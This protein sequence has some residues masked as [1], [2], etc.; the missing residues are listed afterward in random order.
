[1]TALTPV[2]RFNADISRIGNSVWQRQHSCGCQ[3][4]GARVC[5]RTVLHVLLEIRRFAY[6]ISLKTGSLI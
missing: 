2:D 3:R 1:M 4:N 5:R 6:T